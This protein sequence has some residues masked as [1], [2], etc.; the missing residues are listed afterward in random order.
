MW[1]ERGLEGVY[2]KKK[3]EGG[4]K[5]EI[6]KKKKLGFDP[7]GPAGFDLTGPGP[8]LFEPNGEPLE[9]IFK[10]FEINGYG[11]TVPGYRV[12]STRVGV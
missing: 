3:L 11:Y 1:R 6:K 10:I 2:L 5:F 9:G 12:Y 4:I 8:V 7:V